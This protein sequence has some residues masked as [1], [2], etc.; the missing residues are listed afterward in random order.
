MGAGEGRAAA[1]PLAPRQSELGAPLRAPHDRR[2]RRGAVRLRSGA[3]VARLVRVR[4]RARVRIRLR[5]TFR[6]RLRLSEGEA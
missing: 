1:G 5:V 3:P 4:V 6:V 2:R